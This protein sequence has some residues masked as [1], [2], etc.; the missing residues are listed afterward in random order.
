[1]RINDISESYTDKL[2]A[3]YTINITKQNEKS[4]Y[5]TIDALLKTI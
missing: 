5:K 2:Q 4:I 1:M 3:E